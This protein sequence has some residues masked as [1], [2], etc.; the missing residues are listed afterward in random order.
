MSIYR[1]VTVLFILFLSIGQSA[2]GADK[3]ITPKE[4]LDK[5]IEG[6]QRFIDD[7][8]TCPDRNAERR[9]ALTSKQ[10]P[11]AVILGCSDS[12]TPPE[13]IFDQGLG[14]L[15]VVRVAGNVVG[16]VELDSIKYSVLENGSCLIVVLGHENC[17]AVSAVLNHKAQGVPT[18]AALVEKGIGSLK[19]STLPEAILANVSYNVGKLKEAEVFKDLMKQGKLDIIGGYYHFATG[20]VQIMQVRPK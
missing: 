4:A 13:I 10:K 5:L 15:F 19:N 8:T 18:V 1:F 11:F 3:T 7:K 20:E 9:L 2:Y 12:R 6:N 14:E 17:G 16:D